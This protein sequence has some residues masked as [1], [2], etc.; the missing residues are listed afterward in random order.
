MDLYAVIKRPLFTEKGTA[1]KEKDNKVLIEVDSKANKIEIKKA[2]EEIFK[3]KVEKVNTYKRKP[4]RR[5][6]G[7]IPGFTSASKKAIVTLKKGEKLDFIE[8]A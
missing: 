4:K 6:R 1:L 5:M 7:R 8:G 3:V 2:V